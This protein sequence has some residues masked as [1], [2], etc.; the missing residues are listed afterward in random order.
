MHAHMPHCTEMLTLK[1]KA[2]VD[3][4]RC[5]GIKIN[6]LEVQ[7]AAWQIISDWTK[8]QNNYSLQY[9]HPALVCTSCRFKENNVKVSNLN[10]VPILYIFV[11][12]KEGS[13]T[14][15]RTKEEE[16]EKG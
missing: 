14:K 7:H 4:K 10:E 13:K 8:W 6:R 3:G 11:K 15:T 12:E 16:I 5:K 1:E 9:K 2:R